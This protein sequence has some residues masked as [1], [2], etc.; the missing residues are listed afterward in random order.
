MYIST[1]ILSEGELMK[2]KERI[3]QNTIILVTTLIKEFKNKNVNWEKVNRQSSSYVNIIKKSCGLIVSKS[4]ESLGNSLDRKNLKEE[5]RRLLISQLDEKSGYCTKY[6]HY[7]HDSRCVKNDLKNKTIEYLKEFNNDINVSYDNLKKQTLEPKKEAIAPRYIPIKQIEVIASQETFIDQVEVIVAEENIN[8]KNFSMH[9]MEVNSLS[10]KAKYDKNISAIR[11]LK[12]L[13]DKNCQATYEEQQ[14]LA[15]F[16]G[17]GGLSNIFVEDDN[18]GRPKER[19]VLKALVSEKEYEMLRA[20]TLNAFYTPK[21]VIVSIYKIL[22]HM[23]IKKGTALEPAMGIGN[24]LGLVP[25]S[26]DVNF[27]GVELDPITGGIAKLLYPESNIQICGFEKSKHRNKYDLCISNVPYGDYPIY[28]SDYSTQNLLVHDYFIL[29]SLDMLRENGIMAILT[30]KGTMDKKNSKLRELIS[31]KAILLGAIRLPSETFKARAKTEVT[32]DILFFKKVVSSIT[33][34]FT[35]SVSEDNYFINEYFKRNPHMMMGTMKKDI[36]MYGIQ[37]TTLLA[38]EN[39]EARLSEMSD[40][41]PK[42]IYEPLAEMKKNSPSHTNLQVPLL[43]DVPE[44]MIIKNYQYVIVDHHVYQCENDILKYIE[45]SGKKYERMVGL[46]NLKEVAFEYIDLQG[47]H[48]SVN[49]LDSMKKRLNS[50]YDKFVKSNG[51]INTRSNVS[52]FR[53]DPGF[54]LLLALEV[55]KEDKFIKSDMFFKRTIFPEVK[56]TS[57]DT[58]EDALAISLNKHGRVNLEYMSQ[59]TKI[60]ISDLIVELSDNLFYNPV[61]EKWVDK[62]AYLSGNVREKLRIAKESDSKDLNMHQNINALVAIQPK[63]LEAHEISIKLG[64][65][66]IPIDI[67]RDF[68]SFLLDVRTSYTSVDYSSVIATWTLSVIAVNHTKQTK[69]FGTERLSATE[70]I[71]KMLNQQEVKIFDITIED[72]KEKR[73]LNKNETLAA[74]NKKDKIATEFSKW[75][76]NDPERRKRLTKIYNIKFNCI[77]E[78]KYS[79]DMLTFPGMNKTIQ[80][81][82]S[83]SEAVE[84]IVFTGNSLLAHKVGAGKTFIVIAAAMKLGQKGIGIV[85]KPMIVVPN[86][87]LNQWTAEFMRLYPTANILAATKEDFKKEKRKRLF[88]RMATGTFDAILIAHSSFKMLK[89][90]EE[91]LEIFIQDQ[92]NTIEDVIL[93][94][95][96]GN[97][98]TSMVKKLESTKKRLEAEMERLMSQHKKDNGLNFEQIG[99]DH[100]F[101]DEAH[102]F[103]NLYVYTKMGNVSGI[104]QTKSQ[105]AFDL[106]VKSQYI[107]NKYG[108][109]THGLVFAT[110]TPISNSMVE[111]YTMQRYMQLST[112]QDMGLGHFDAW[113]ALF[114]ESVTSL[115]ISPDGSGYRMKTRF[116]KFNNLPE[117]MSLYTQFADIRT[118]SMLKLPIPKLKNGKAKIIKCEASEELITFVQTL[119]NRAEAISRGLIDPRNDNMLK[120]TS[121]GRKVATDPRLMIPD[122]EVTDEFKVVKAAKEIYSR[123]M[124]YNEHKLTQLV[125]CDLSTPNKHK[126]NVYD[127]LKNL[128]IT[129]GIHEE[130][131]AFIHDA[132]TDKQKEKLFKQVNSGEVRVLLGSTP[133]LGAG[134]NV[135]GDVNRFPYGGGLQ[136]I[137]HLDAPWRPSDIEQRDGRGLRPGNRCLELGIEFELL[138]FVTTKSFDAYSWQT[139]ETKARFLDQLMLGNTSVRSIESS[140]T[141]ALNFAEIKAIASDNPLVFKKLSIDS[142]VEQLS[143]LKSIYNRDMYRMQDRLAMIPLTIEKM[144]QKITLY[145][146]DLTRYLN[147]S[148]NKVKIFEDYFEVEEAGQVI[149][150]LANNVTHDSSIKIG[151]YMNYD[152]HL[153]KVTDLYEEETVVMSLVNPENGSEHKVNMSSMASIN[154]KRLNSIFKNIDKGIKDLELK[155]DVQT[156]SYES[157]KEEA[158]KKFD[159]EDR[160]TYLL[161]EQTEINAEFNKSD[162]TTAEENKVS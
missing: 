74:R 114:G 81:R 128:L 60:K 115:E 57:A 90:S 159:N 143:V 66:W 155:L 6:I 51:Y 9:S 59:L 89:M 156:R 92:I 145:Y 62:G 21:H 108:N 15:E 112:L 125:F 61:K 82:K 37:N 27:Q 88:A 35:S 38:S 33:E 69:T 14:V 116:S 109:G 113:A 25:D 75:I 2:F 52:L 129:K 40:Y 146:E 102:E 161:K 160:L 142:E 83:Q 19:E 55:E 80:L 20:S 122:A 101:V 46:I 10:L 78:R 48:I 42:D 141:T 99:I 153:Y 68:V 17:F 96:E 157:L 64:A 84:R 1:F 77:R 121:E 144:K 43:L 36:N 154:M 7:L 120:I 136:A 34:S 110:G 73:V 98:Y 63:D 104:P 22:T 50:I 152:L 94:T 41:F 86:H 139:L 130:E 3:K 13:E 72:G 23:G 106:F 32:T 45:L 53:E 18:K 30:T 137:H 151:E 87:L 132:N 58:A 150:D 119:V 47:Q 56:I 16:T 127:E 138:R 12:T 31:K 93:S 24:F 158:T 149:K 97:K 79:G 123:Y 39:W 147:H 54:P 131:I 124:L 118:G 117:L 105:K 65:P 11:V 134:T 70:T 126:F 67:I 133:K 148:T 49:E 100:L 95:T 91:S 111:M 107:I 162:E 140:D 28:D 135:Q 4:N 26:W 85:N 103:K 8:C 71:I 44:D 76:Y 5:Y 29:K